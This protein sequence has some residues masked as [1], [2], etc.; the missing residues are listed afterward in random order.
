MEQQSAAGVPPRFILST[1][2]QNDPDC[3]IRPVDVYNRRREQRREVL[4][5]RSRLEALKAD[6]EATDWTYYIWAG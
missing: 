3:P 6:L 4:G 1:L 2:R 5:G